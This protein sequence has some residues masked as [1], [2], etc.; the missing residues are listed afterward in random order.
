MSTSDPALDQRLREQPAKEYCQRLAEEMKAFPPASKLA[1]V[2]PD[3]AAE[4]SK[5]LSAALE[6]SWSKALDDVAE[7]PKAIAD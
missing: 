1:G 2:P 4:Q 3:A 5:A 7:K 6:E